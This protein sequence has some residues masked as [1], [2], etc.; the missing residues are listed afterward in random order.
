[1]SGRLPALPLAAAAFIAGCISGALIGGPWTATLLAA[2][3]AGAAVALVRLRRGASTRALLLLIAVIALA[4]AGHARGSEADSRPPPPLASLEGVHEITGVVRSDPRVSGAITRLDL[5][6]ES[7]DGAAAEGG[8]R[9]RLPSP[10]QPL[11]AGDR[12]AATLEVERP[13]AFDEFDYATFLRSRGI[14][15][16]AAYPQRWTLLERDAEHAIVDALR[17]LRRWALGNIERALPE[18][19]ASLA[20]GMLLGRQRTMPAAL[21]EDLRRTGTT[22]LLVVSGQNIALLLGTAVGLLGALV[23]RAAGSADRAR[24]AAGLRRSH[25][26]GAAGGACGDHGRRHRDRRDQRAA[27]ARLDLPRLRARAD[28]GAAAAA[29][30]RRGLPAERDGDGRRAADRAAVA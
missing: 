20:A 23:A 6:V 21:E 9:L 17:G 5:R 28:V 27:H 4:A 25:G 30:P 12:L 8:L 14:H 29:D 10:L 22:H 24:A 3:A 13:G 11:R 16:V 7:I 2:L 18:P 26:R 15:A 1:M 19:E